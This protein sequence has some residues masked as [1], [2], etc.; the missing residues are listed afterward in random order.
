[1]E[2]SKSKVEMDGKRKLR[3]LPERWECKS[4]LGLIGRSMELDLLIVFLS[5]NSRDSCES[6]FCWCWIDW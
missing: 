1:M 3:E 5:I 6:R 4:K 2:R